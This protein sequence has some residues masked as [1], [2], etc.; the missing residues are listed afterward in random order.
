VVPTGSSEEKPGSA[1]RSRVNVSHLRRENELYRIVEGFGGMINIQTKEFFE[2]HMNL[3]ETLSKAGEPTSAP[4]GTRTDKRTATATFNSL[5][6]KGRVKQL[7]TSVAT[8]TGVNRPACIVYLPH[9]DHGKL[10]AFLADLARGSQPTP[11]QLGTFVKFDKPVEY[12]ADPSSANRGALP[13]QLLQMEQ[14]GDSKERWS[15]NVARA[16]QLFTYD[17]STIREVLLTER[18]TLGQLYGFI[19][20]K[21]IRAR[22][23]H[24]SVLNAFETGSPCRN[25][26]SCERR[27]IDLGFFCHDLP[28][29]LYTSLVSS[30]SH[31]DELTA[32]F[33]TTEGRQT[34]VR[35]LPQSLHS[36]LQIGRSRARSR[37]LD[38]LET[39]RS[40]QLVTPL[41]PS[42]AS[43]PWI[44]CPPNGDHPTKF[45]PASLDG[46]TI[47]TP[48]SAPAYW[49]FSDLAPIHLWAV[50]EIQPPFWKDTCVGTAADG[51]N[52]WE[53]M[54]EACINPL[55]AVNANVSSKLGPL[56]PSIS[57]ARSLRR[58]VS[59]K[60]DYILTWHQMQYLK[61]FIDVASGKTPMQ[62]DE[63][64]CTSQIERICRVTS[65]PRSTI[66]RYFRES[67]VKLLDD[68]ERMRRKDKGQ[69]AE[70]RSRRATETKVS[71]ARKAEEARL[72]REQEWNMLLSRVHPDALGPATVRVDRVRNRFVQTGSTKD[73]EKWE[74]EIHNAVREAGLVAMKTLKTSAKRNS[75]DKRNLPMILPDSHPQV[76]EVSCPSVKTLIEQQGPPILHQKEGTKRKR[77]SSAINEGTFSF[78]SLWH[79]WLNINR[80]EGA[81]CSEKVYSTAP[82]SMVSRL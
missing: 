53:S 8:H 23:L 43:V 4:A 72:N 19:V 82:I 14:P 5:E 51:L 12:G 27:I 61:Q 49:H 81:R 3:L 2:A 47:N 48:M 29:S 17:D 57:V 60:P 80:P 33:G 73:I 25:V 30:L 16:S 74:K 62:E 64:T 58:S 65:A 26:I 59:W 6:I 69:K 71:L 7:R 45:D 34:A 38:I 56:N 37:F 42:T 63:D 75:T 32:F 54:R 76:I 67:R 44:T 50:S 36:I 41:Q 46:W 21:V 24:L 22:E 31:D 18:T 77:K 79:L 11:P 40:L 68:L 9:V 1:S 66:E 70:K 15:K 55:V 39:L 52:Y 20:G 78:A 13:L 35:D 28:L 10:N